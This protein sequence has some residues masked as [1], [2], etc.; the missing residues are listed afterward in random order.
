MTAPGFGVWPVAAGISGVAHVVVLAGLALVLRPVPPPSQPMPE[1]RLTVVAAAVERSTAPAMAPGGDIAPATKAD[2]PL[3]QRAAPTQ[4]RAKAVAPDGMM[5]AVSVARSD[6]LQPVSLPDAVVQLSPTSSPDAV[7]P[8]QPSAAVILA[9]VAPGVVVSSQTAAAPPV[10]P[11]PPAGM[12]VSALAPEARRAAPAP[13]PATSSAVPPPSAR[14][15]TDPALGPV[16]GGRVLPSDRLTAA[17]AWTGDAG[18]VDPLSLA[19]IQSFMQAGDPGHGAD[20]VRDGIGQVL[21]SVP[22]GRLQTT[23]DPATGTLELRGHIPEDG[24]RAPVLAAIR[25]R[26]GTAIPVVDRVGILPR[27]QCGALAGFAATGLPQSTEQ[28]TNPRVIGADAQVRDY[29]YAEGER[30]VLDLTA[31]DYPAYVHVDYF[32]AAGNVLHLQP[33]DVVPLRLSAPK[34]VLAV[35]Q[36][37]PGVPALALTVAPPFGQEIAVAFATSDPVIAG[38]RPMVEPA[39]PYLAY[40]AGRMAAARAAN[41]D[42]KGEWVYFFITTAQR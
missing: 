15:A 6:A 9:S 29:R 24:L 37:A 18:P 5:A 33:N 38:G 2:A 4:T 40:L 39:G 21:A 32:D 25:D 34:S 20:L 11:V 14:V 22:C 8:L 27:P 41:P 7:V 26:I 10:A 3:S 28:D 30:L 36:D 1:T 16:L 35:G 42:F 31:P 13:G 19:V 17:L 23:F 12:S